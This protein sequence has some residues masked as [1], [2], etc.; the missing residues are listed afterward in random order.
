M[1]TEV[2]SEIKE[3]LVQRITNKLFDN[4][5]ENLTKE[6]PV[7]TSKDSEKQEI[8]Q[9][10]NELYEFGLNSSEKETLQQVER[11]AEELTINV[12]RTLDKLIIHY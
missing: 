10:E 1:D 2:E 12:L 9:L 4:S 5:V 7:P 11:E 3:C 8:E 6:Q